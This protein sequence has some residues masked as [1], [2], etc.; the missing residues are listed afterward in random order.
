MFRIKRKKKEKKKNAGQLQRPFSRPPLLERKTQGNYSRRC[1]LA[2]GRLSATPCPIPMARPFAVWRNGIL[3]CRF[4]KEAPLAGKKKKTHVCN[5]QLAKVSFRKKK[6]TVPSR[7]NT[8]FFTKQPENVP[9]AAICL[10]PL[11]KKTHFSNSDRVLLKSKG[12]KSQQLFLNQWK[13][14]TEPLSGACEGRK[15]TA[16]TSFGPQ[17]RAEGARPS[18]CTKVILEVAGCR[19]TRL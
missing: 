14:G 8:L 9:V 15:N 11:E 7:R 19:D 3:F 18:A 16:T 12:E 1:L 2:T 10:T 5:A 4:A 13:V 17:V 6:K